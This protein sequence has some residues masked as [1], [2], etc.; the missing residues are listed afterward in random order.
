MEKELHYL[1][2]YDDLTG[3]PN[4]IHYKRV[5]KVS[6]KEAKTKFALLNLEIKGLK[7][8]DYSL[9]Y[10]VGNEII[11]EIVERLKAYLNEAFNRYSDEQFTIILTRLNPIASLKLRQLR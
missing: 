4:N 5:Q 6:A 1:S 10:E 8:I 7:Y 9:G 3:L 11:I 2:N